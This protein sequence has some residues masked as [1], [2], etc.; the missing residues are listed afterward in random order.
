MKFPS[1]LGATLASA[2]KILLK[3]RKASAPEPE[4]PER[5]MVILGNGPSL[6]EAMERHS[7]W[8]A[9]R[10]LMAVNFAANTFAWEKLKPHW[11]V[12]A[13]P[14][15]WNRKPDDNLQRLWQNLRSAQWPV[16]LFVPCPRVKATRRLLGEAPNVRVKG[17]NMTPVDGF[18]WFRHAAWRR[19]WGMPRPRN[20]LIPA[21]MLA[22]HEGFTTVMLAGADHSWTRTLSVDDQ[23]RVVTVQP[24]FYEDNREEHQR[25]ASV[26]RDVHLHNILESLTIAFR[27]YHLIAA[28][29]RKRG[30]DVINITPGSFIDAFPRRQL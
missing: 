13:D 23:N 2:A 12:L 3:S 22:L 10:E 29:A 24:H 9:G 26:Y 21:I 7:D 6:N 17:F 16:A 11:Y 8:L 27:S 20:V 25:V 15:F 4:R 30:A 14:H 28:Y 18:R 1:A 5:E 19:G